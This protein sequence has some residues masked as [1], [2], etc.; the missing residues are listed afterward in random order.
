MAASAASSSA[1]AT[2]GAAAPSATDGSAAA[3]LGG[4]TTSVLV[5]RDISARKRV[6]SRLGLR[7][8]VGK[9]RRI[10]R[11][12]DDHGCRAGRCR[13]DHLR[14]GC[15]VGHSLSGCHGRLWGF[16]SA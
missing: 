1:T 11:C 7:R 8:S 3:E 12:D 14:S 9:D 13:L 5:V 16:G 2:G 15:G 4:G 10:G 6:E